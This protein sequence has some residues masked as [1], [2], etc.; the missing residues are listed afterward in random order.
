[1]DNPGPPALPTPSRPAGRG[2]QQGTCGA[3][4]RAREPAKPMALVPPPDRRLCATTMARSPRHRAV[5]ISGSSSSARQPRCALW[6]QSRGCVAAAVSSRSFP[7]QSEKLAADLHERAFRARPDGDLPC[8]ASLVA[9]VHLDIGTLDREDGGGKQRPWRVHG[10]Q[11]RDLGLR[12][13][14]AGA[15]PEPVQLPSHRRRW[16]RRGRLR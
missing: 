1:M 8:L 10:R 7:A 3:L 6:V 4:L 15:G 11:R 16:R 9:R 5:Q 12:H 13:A 14:G 2:E